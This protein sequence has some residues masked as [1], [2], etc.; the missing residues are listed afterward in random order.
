[1][2]IG[3]FPTPKALQQALWHGLRYGAILG[4]GS[5]LFALLIFS[6]TLGWNTAL[7]RGGTLVVFVGFNVMLLAALG[8]VLKFQ[9]STRGSKQHYTHNSNQ[10]LNRCLDFLYFSMCGA[11]G[12]TGLYA[13]QSGGLNTV[14]LANASITSFFFGLLFAV[15]H[16]VELVQV[17]P[18]IRPAETVAWSWQNVRVDLMRNMKKGLV[19]GMAIFIVVAVA[20]TCISTFFHGIGYGFIYGV[21]FGTITGFITGI[22]SILT[23]ILAGGW[24]SSVITDEH[25]FVRPNEGIRRS[26]YH[27]LFA[28]CIFG[29]I[30]GVV[31]GGVSGIAFGLAGVAGWFILGMG[32]S[33]VFSFL[34]AF[35]FFINHGGNAVISHYA[36]RWCLWRSQSLPLNAVDF[37]NY[38]T[39]RILLRKVGGGYMFT[40]RLLLE[41]FV[42]LEEM[43]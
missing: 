40:H 42:S 8:T 16:R 9:R 34:L 30:G 21:V 28:A 14:V 37:L 27:A 12:F 5:G 10:L 13:L 18:D 38:A 43:P 4:I 33:I 25:Q 2:E 7:L 17:D 29:P 36:L 23:A 15:A 3:A 22:T 32:F 11:I 24:E 20:L 31:S 6:R 39:E 1:M 19:L 26:M 35:H 41:Y